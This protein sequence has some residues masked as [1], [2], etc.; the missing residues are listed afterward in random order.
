M[1]IG[2]LCSIYTNRGELQ[3]ALEL[4]EQMLQIAQSQQ[5]PILLLWA[6]YSLGFTLAD[7]G[8]L[9]SAL[10]HLER[11]LELYDPGQ[12][13]LRYYVQ[14]PGVTSSVRLALLLFDLGC[15]ETALRKGREAVILARKLSHP[16]SLSFALAYLSELHSERGEYLVAQQLAEE[17]TA[18]A[19]QHGLLHLA[20]LGAN[21]RAWALIGQGLNQE[22]VQ[23]ME[24]GLARLSNELPG[25]KRL[26]HKYLLAAA[27]KKLQRPQEALVLIGEL[28]NLVNQTGKRSIEGDLHRLKGELLLQEDGKNEKGAEQSYRDAILVARRQRAR[29]CELRATT[30]LARLL[31]KQDR[32]NEAR[33]MLADIYGW[34]TEGF[35]TADLKDAKA[36]LDELAT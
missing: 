24:E 18:L 20:T 28:L 4:G 23:L 31:A 26:Y 7:R 33:A 8:E 35:D 6:N 3:I 13:Y 17:A 30:S 27:Y 1:M 29:A 16:Y 2:S 36:L 21:W 25:E 15:P 12:D 14:D 32:R 22:G 34:F 9:I 10:S 5:N 11:T 19:D